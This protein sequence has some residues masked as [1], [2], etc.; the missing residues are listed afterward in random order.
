V[1][2]IT[3]PRVLK[4]IKDGLILPLY[5][6]FAKSLQDG[7]LPNSWKDATITAIH[8]KGSLVIT[9]QYV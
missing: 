5:L 6:L 4:E 9:I 1:V 2:L 8:K 3:H 7:V